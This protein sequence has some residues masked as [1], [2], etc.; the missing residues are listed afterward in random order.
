MVEYKVILLDLIY[1]VQLPLPRG[2]SNGVG[3]SMIYKWTEAY[4]VCLEEVKEYDGGYVHSIVPKIGRILEKRLEYVTDGKQVANRFIG[5]MCDHR[6][7]RVY[8]EWKSK[9]SVEQQRII[10]LTARLRREAVGM[11]RDMV[12]PMSVQ[13][14]RFKVAEIRRGLNIKDNKAIVQD[15]N[16]HV[17]SLKFQVNQYVH[18]LTHQDGANILENIEIHPEDDAKT[19]QEKAQK[20]RTRSRVMESCT[21]WGKKAF[22]FPQ[23]FDSRGRIY[24]A[25]TAGISVIGDDLEAASIEPLWVEKLTEDG[26]KALLE[27]LK[28]Y[29]EQE[30]SVQKMVYH[31]LNPEETKDEWMTAEKPL[32][33]IANAK[34]LARYMEDSEAEL[35]CFVPL[36]GRASA[37][38]HWSALLRSDAVTKYIGMEEE[39]PQK[40]MYEHYRDIVHPHIAQPQQWIMEGSTGRK[41]AKKPVMT[42]A[43]GGKL[44]ST[45]EYI[46]KEFRRKATGKELKEVSTVLYDGLKDLLK[47]I[48][49]GFEWVTKV[50]RIISQGR[51]RVYWQTPDGFIASQ[52]KVKP[53]ETK[54]KTL[55]Q[56]GN[57]FKTKY[58]DYEI[59]TP[60]KVG[61]A[62]ALSPNLIHSLDACHLRMVCR[63]MKDRG[64]PVI[65]VHDSFATHVNHREELYQIIKEQFVLMYNE[66]VLQN[67]K[68]FWE[69]N[70]LVD[71]PEPPELGDYDVSKILDLDLFFT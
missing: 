23:F 47:D 3:R 62:N 41:A 60:H 2:G 9:N 16:D 38:Q 19:A 31:A 67:L 11:P 52:R 59:T 49:H 43:Y 54:V 46:Q 4:N 26:Y 48:T 36:D 10:T 27:T 29:S 64:L 69:Y 51:E 35:P 30:W 7:L 6:Y 63:E 5:E 13:K 34:Y 18:G 33:Y 24:P 53:K 42:F 50:A 68:D 56:N 12:N 20:L 22:W 61:H 55:L 57:I 39:E 37:L 58:L 71:L 40:D 44:S 21:L 28:G 45:E 15:V 32:K 66:N 65:F 25:T 8:L 70:Y 17:S 1:G 14:Y